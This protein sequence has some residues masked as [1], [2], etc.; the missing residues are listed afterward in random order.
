MMQKKIIG[1]GWQNFSKYIDSFFGGMELEK[2]LGEILACDLSYYVCGGIRKLFKQIGHRIET[3][4]RVVDLW[5]N[6]VG[7]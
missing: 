5:Q 1:L 7:W 2:L 4:W 6:I 3:F